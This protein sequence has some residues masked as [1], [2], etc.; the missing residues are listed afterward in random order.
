MSEQSKSNYQALGAGLFGFV[1][2]M[3]VG[4]GALMVHRS[5]QASASAAPAAAGAPI[6]LGA[7][8]PAPRHAMTPAALKERR[9]ESPAPL[10]GEVEESEPAEAPAVPAEASS[11]RSSAPAPTPESAPEARPSSSRLA[12][13]QHVD[14][15]AGDATAAA[16]AVASAPPPEKAL[17]VPAKKPA[18]KKAPL[19]VEAGSGAIAS[20][21]YGATNRSELMGRAAGPVYNMKGAG[22]RPGSGAVGKMADD[23]N[24]KI[25]DLQKQLESVGMPADQRAKLQK[26]LEDVT[27]G[28]IPPSA[29][30]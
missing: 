23:V 1:A 3:A 15:G 9:A 20:V 16:A 14:A 25:A 24:A 18:V 22:P 11:R 12:V 7:S 29:A 19:A 2:V 30:Q 10:I 5:Q 17:K 28:A 6:D 27:K 26:D 13:T 8:M 21:H 4:G